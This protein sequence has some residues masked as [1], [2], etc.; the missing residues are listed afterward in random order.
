MTHRVYTANDLVG[1]PPHQS[2]RLIGTRSP[3][4]RF[5]FQKILNNRRK[6][7]SRDATSYFLDH[8]GEGYEWL[9]PGWLVEERILN[10]TNRQYKVT[11]FFPS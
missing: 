11:N 3:L 8:H 1:R 2:V 6:K 4:A 9:L 10:V 5:T 7:T